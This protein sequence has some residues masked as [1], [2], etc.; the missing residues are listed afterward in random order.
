MSVYHLHARLHEGALG[1]PDARYLFESRESDD[2]AEV[3]RAAKE[4]A[5]G[6]FTVVVYDHGHRAALPGASDYRQLAKYRPDGR[7]ERVSRPEA[8]GDRTTRKIG[9]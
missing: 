1:H 9:Q 5:E 2:L 3:T 6:G 7:V 4:L 8:A